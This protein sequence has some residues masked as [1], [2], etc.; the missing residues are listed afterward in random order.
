MNVNRLLVTSLVFALGFLLGQRFCIEHHQFAA[1]APLL[2]TLSLDLGD[3]GIYPG[4]MVMMQQVLDTI[5]AVET[6]GHPDPCWAVGDG[7]KS[8]GPYQIGRAYF[9]DGIE[10]LKR[11]GLDPGLVY[12]DVRNQRDAERI[13]LAYWRRY[14][15][16]PY[17]FTE[18]CRLHN[19]GPTMRGTDVYIAKCFA[20]LDDL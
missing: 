18:L 2:G 10:Q 19:G 20:I 6:G 8:I 16:A 14:A 1:T 7:G 17:E 9:H 12:E 3:V 5:R 11:E 13:V 15:T 4:S